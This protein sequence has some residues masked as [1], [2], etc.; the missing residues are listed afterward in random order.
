LLAEAGEAVK[1][2]RSA[3]TESQ[4]KA[5]KPKLGAR[6]WSREQSKNDEKGLAGRRHPSAD[7]AKAPEFPA[8]REK[9]R[10]YPVSW[11]L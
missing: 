2:L 9:I 3:K 5:K 7:V 10:E 6:S 1:W 4:P 8:N 11:R